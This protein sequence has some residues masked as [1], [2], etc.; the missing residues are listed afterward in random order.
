[1]IM[2]KDVQKFSRLRNYCMDVKTRAIIFVLGAEVITVFGCYTMNEAINRYINT[3]I[4][5]K[6]R[7]T[8][9]AFNYVVHLIMVNNSGLKLTFTCTWTLHA[10]INKVVG[11]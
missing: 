2:E 11:T 6:S 5:P 9:C 10:L 1:M 8:H 7:D 4:L 3:E